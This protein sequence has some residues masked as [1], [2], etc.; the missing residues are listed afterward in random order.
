MSKTA[1]QVL[2]ITLAATTP[3]T[4]TATMI[5]IKMLNTM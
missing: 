4:T 5:A 3:T 2:G 1:D